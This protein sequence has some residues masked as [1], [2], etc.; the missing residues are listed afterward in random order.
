MRI[1]YL[2]SQ[3][4]ATSHTFIRREVLA[5]REHGIDVRTY[6]VRKPGEHERQTADERAEFDATWYILPPRLDL[7]GA[8]LRGLFRNP[9]R[10][11]RALGDALRHRVPGL[12]ALVYAVL[13][14]GET[15]YLGDR[16]RSDGITH[17]HNHFANPAGNVG[18]LVSRYLGITWSIT[19]HGI[20]EF[21]YPA[22]QLLGAKLEHADFI[23]CVSHFTRAQAMRTI[24]PA[25]W[26]KLFLNR[27][28]VRIDDLK[29]ATRRRDETAQLRIVCVARLSP[30]KGLVGLV[31][32]FARLRERGVDAQLRILGDGPSRD[33]ILAAIEQAGVAAHCE[34][35]GRIP[36]TG[37]PV[38]LAD[39]DIFAMTSFME[40]LPVVLMEA[41]ALGLPVVAPCVAGIP[42]LVEH[43]HT[44]LL[45]GPAHWD[46]LTCRLERLARD[47][48]LRR[49]LGAAGRAR[50]EAEFDASKAAAPIV[51]K[52]L[53]LESRD[54]R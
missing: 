22:G 1:A 50:V 23:A 40:G 25:H 26:P 35:P 9:W 12:R 38:E 19:L 41:L 49:R 32:A 21:D 39:A 53:A 14:F 17:L 33:D 54:E 16:L 11:F 7:V 18:Y 29:R 5:V 52:F 10:Y 2:T 47:P 15:I 31:Q 34:L 6:S 20:S 44:G 37:V 51:A 42:D 30:E 36:E 3:Y 13:Y 43:E 48:A 4:P 27:C 28:G 45:F 46:E 8:H 24:A